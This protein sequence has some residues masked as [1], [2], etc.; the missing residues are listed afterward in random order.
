[1]RERILDL[2][3]F[4]AVLKLVLHSFVKSRAWATKAP[5]W[6]SDWD[7]LHLEEASAGK[8]LEQESLVS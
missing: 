1:M 5:V 3:I 7:C 8:D 2:V 4:W 6:Q